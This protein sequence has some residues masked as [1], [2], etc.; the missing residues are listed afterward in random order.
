METM[1]RVLKIAA[2]AALLMTAQL[3]AAPAAESN[4]KQ[5]APKAGGP[6]EKV[7]EDIITTGSRIASRR[8]CGTRAEWEAKRRDDRAVTEQIQTRLNGP[9]S[10]INQHSGTPAC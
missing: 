5:D 4:N 2:S 10:V 7:C 3:G 6:G 8:F 1:M 9:C